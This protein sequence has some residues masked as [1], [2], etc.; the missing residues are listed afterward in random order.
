MSVF[1]TPPPI[2][3]R[4]PNLNKV[5]VDFICDVTVAAGFVPRWPAGRQA[6]TTQLA[7]HLPNVYMLE[8][9][10]FCGSD[11]CSS[12][13]NRQHIQNRLWEQLLYGTRYYSRKSTS[14]KWPTFSLARATTYRNWLYQF[15]SMQTPVWPA[16][17]CPNRGPA[18][19]RYRKF[20]RLE[21]ASYVVW[22]N[23]FGWQMF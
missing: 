23:Y 1:G 5:K 3:T 8:S 20:E 10:G 6:I 19:D 4:S 13:N 14:R 12:S 9:F 16:W 22:L 15:R 21:P 2:P 11:S 18:L 17:N 7:P